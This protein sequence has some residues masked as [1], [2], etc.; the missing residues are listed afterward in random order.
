MAST[1]MNAVADTVPIT[2]FYFTYDIVTNFFVIATFIIIIINI[3]NITNITI[4]VLVT[5]IIRITVIT[6]MS[7]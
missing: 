3:T 2:Y 7:L 4:T 1:V 6:I 5:R